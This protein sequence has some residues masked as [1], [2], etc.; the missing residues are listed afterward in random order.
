LTVVEEAMSYDAHLLSGRQTV[1]HAP[2]FELSVAGLLHTPQ[3]DPLV[4]CALV[5]QAMPSA[6]WFAQEPV[7]ALQY[8]P[9][10]QPVVV[11]VV[12][13]PSPSQSEAEMAVLPLQLGCAQ[14]AEVP[15]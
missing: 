15:G 4:H 14:M 11:G 7:L 6:S 1:P 13:S 3:Q 2:Q 10:P 9:A 12:Q 8:V 5:W